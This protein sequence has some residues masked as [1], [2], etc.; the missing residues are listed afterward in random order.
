MDLKGTHV[1][2]TPPPP[3]SRGTTL[4][5]PPPFRD[6]RPLSSTQEP[7][8]SSFCKLRFFSPTRFSLPLLRA[9]WRGK[10]GQRRKFGRRRVGLRSELES[11]WVAGHIHCAGPRGGERRAGAGAVA[12]VSAAPLRRFT[13][14]PQAAAVS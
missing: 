11:G 1:C 13:W 12:L 4:Q 7:T 10:C 3:R 14:R 5:P 8:S 2:L 6:S 9:D